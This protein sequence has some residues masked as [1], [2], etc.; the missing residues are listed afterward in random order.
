MTK[1]PYADSSLARFLRQRIAD[2]RPMTQAEIAA[3]AGYL[4]ANVI[5]MLK[6]GTTKLAIDRVPDMAKA[7][8]ADPAL[9]LRLVLEQHHGATLA[10]AIFEIA[11][12]MP[13][14]NERQLIQEFRDVT[15]GSDPRLTARTRGAFRAIWER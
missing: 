1:K 15:G 12:P 8:Q 6:D 2:L 5:S 9:L 7:L 11:G 3:R 10:R 14:E 4:N 13:T